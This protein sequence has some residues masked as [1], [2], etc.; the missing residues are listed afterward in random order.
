MRVVL[1]PSETKRDGGVEGSALALESLA[2]PALTAHR[3]AAIAALTRLSRNVSASTAALGLGP[4]QRF[5]VDRNR[6]IRTATTMPAIDRYTGV[7][8]EGLASE[9]L[10]ADAHAWLAHHVVVHSALFGLLGASDAIPAYRLSHDSRV[11]G[12]A[13][14]KHW[15][16]PI[17]EQLAGVDDLV[18]DL[19]SEAYAHLGPRPEGSFYLRVVTDGPN[20]QKRALN[21]FNKKGKGEFVRELALDGTDHA[22]VESLLEWAAERGI[23]LG[24]GAPG[25]LELT[26]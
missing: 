25:E 1:P 11:P 17:A 15:A 19:R 23:R 21:H 10:D 24:H 13:L 26:V 6:V 16:A 7:L 14:R 20:G 18:L 2:F 22:E 4:T 3:A 8:F 12:L 5:E 9:S